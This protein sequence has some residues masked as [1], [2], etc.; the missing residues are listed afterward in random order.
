M[1]SMKFTEEDKEKVIAFLNSVAK[2]ATFK[3]DT[4]ELIEHFKLLAHMQSAILPKVEAN[5]FEV[6]K[7]TK[8][9]K[10]K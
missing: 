3:M 6:K 10:S 5:I 1:D 7:V 2:C 4:Q 9:K 8:P